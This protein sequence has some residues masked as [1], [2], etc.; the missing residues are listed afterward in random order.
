[1][2]AIFFMEVKCIWPQYCYWSPQR[3][4]L[5][6]HTPFYISKKLAL[7]QSNGRGKCSISNVLC[8]IQS[9][10]QIYITVILIWNS[11][12][13]TTTFY[14]DKSVAIISHIKRGHL[15]IDKSVAIFQTGKSVISE[16]RQ[17]CGHLLTDKS[18]KICWQ[19]TVWSSSHRQKCGHLLADNN[20]VVFFLRDHGN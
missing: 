9:R 19:T 8:G 2:S 10:I 18:V 4:C 7:I 13:V 12:W 17:Q 11:L 5:L 3:D 16:H 20:F 1:M 15:N 14:I 6:K